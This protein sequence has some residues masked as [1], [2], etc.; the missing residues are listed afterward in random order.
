MTR[1]LT[2]TLIPGYHVIYFFI[3][4][5]DIGCQTRGQYVYTQANQFID[6][7]RALQYTAGTKKYTNSLK[8]I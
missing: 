8:L 4:L 2:D 3:P 7:Y 6:N 5:L 1:N